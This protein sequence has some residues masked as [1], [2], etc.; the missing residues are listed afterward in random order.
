[1]YNLKNLGFQEIFKGLIN[2]RIKQF[3]QIGFL[4]ADKIF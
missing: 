2:L 1:M 4:K 3:I